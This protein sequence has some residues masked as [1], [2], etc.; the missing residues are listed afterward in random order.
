MKCTDCKTGK[1]VRPQRW[2]YDNH[3]CHFY[4]VNLTGYVYI[5]I[6]FFL[7]CIYRQSFLDQ[8][9]LVQKCIFLASFPWLWHNRLDC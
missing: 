5:Y 2:I 9:C 3:S 8:L 7:L 4:I 1:I 6:F